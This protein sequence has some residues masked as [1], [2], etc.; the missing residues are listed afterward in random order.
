MQTLFA[1]SFFLVLL[2][3]LAKQSAPHKLEGKV[4]LFQNNLSNRLLPVAAPADPHSKQEL[5]QFVMVWALASSLQKSKKL[6]VFLAHC[7]PLDYFAWADQFPDSSLQASHMSVTTG[8]LWVF[9]VLHDSVKIKDD[10][11]MSGQGQ[12]LPVARAPAFIIQWHGVCRPGWRQAR[13]SED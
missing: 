13:L 10:D 6:I 7:V 5:F 9:L 3:L 12:K 8:F 2:I 4:Q 1:F 11:A